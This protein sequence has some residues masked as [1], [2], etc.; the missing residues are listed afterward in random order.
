MRMMGILPLETL[1]LSWMAL[2]FSLALA[3]AFSLADPLALLN[4]RLM[5]L[6]TASMVLLESDSFVCF[7]RRAFVNHVHDL[8][9]HGHVHVG[10]PLSRPLPLSLSFV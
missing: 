9:R 7:V 3:L 10:G 1:M 6:Y 5:F 2:A 4:W 8:H